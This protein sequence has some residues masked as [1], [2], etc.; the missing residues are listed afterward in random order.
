M[1]V[2]NRPPAELFV[3]LREGGPQIAVSIN[4]FNKGLIGRI[5]DTLDEAEERL[6]ADEHHTID[7]DA[8]ED[9]VRQKVASAAIGASDYLGRLADRINRG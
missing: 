4:S 5:V 1:T 9:V 6:A 3:S 2:R 8:L 7:I